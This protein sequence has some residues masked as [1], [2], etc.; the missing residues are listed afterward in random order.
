MMPRKKVEATLTPQLVHSMPC[1]ELQL[2]EQKMDTIEKWMD[3]QNGSMAKLADANAQMPER[4]EALRRDINTDRNQAGAFMQAQVTGM[5][6][7]INQVPERIDALRRDLQADREPR[8]VQIDKSFSDIRTDF[9]SFRNWIIGLG[10][11]V[12]ALI[13][14]TIGVGIALVNAV[15]N[16]P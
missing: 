7:A 14:S 15:A 9:S 16:K 8:F 12:F 3:R 1:S 10:L 6:A 11:T 5:Q 2:V 13:I 4:I